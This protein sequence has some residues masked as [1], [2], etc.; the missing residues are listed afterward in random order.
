MSRYELFDRR[1]IELRPI[2][3]RGHDLLADELPAAW[4]RRESPYQHPSF[5]AYSSGSR[6]ARQAGRRSC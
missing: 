3:E 2:A 5:L 6:S 1:R 4:P